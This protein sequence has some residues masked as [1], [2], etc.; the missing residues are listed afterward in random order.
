M[1]H[2]ASAIEQDALRLS[3]PQVSQ[4]LANACGARDSIKRAYRTGTFA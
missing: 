3:T 2:E 4:T 1:T